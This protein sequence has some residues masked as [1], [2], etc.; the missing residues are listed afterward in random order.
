MKIITLTLKLTFYMILG[1]NALGQVRVCLINIFRNTL[2][3]GA[4][5]AF[6]TLYQAHS[7]VNYLQVANV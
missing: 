4:L 5:L 6:S 2:K 7:T 1:I 3:R